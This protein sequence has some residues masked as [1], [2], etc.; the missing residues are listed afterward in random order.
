MKAQMTA[1]QLKNSILQMAV[2]GKLVPQDSKDEPAS[3]LLERIRAEKEQLIKEKKIKKG[4]IFSVIF[5]AADNLPYTFYEKTFDGKVHDI[6]DELPFEIPKSWEWVRLKHIL[7]VKGGKRI[8]KG[9]FLSDI[10]TQNIYIRV[11]DM[12]NN[13]IVSNKLQYISD[14]V[15]KIISKYTIGKDDLYLTIAG[16]IGNVGLVPAMFDEM[17]LTE[18]A[19]KLTNIG[20]DKIFLLY[21]LQSPL[22]QEQFI[23]KTNQVAQPKLAIERILT[24]L[25]PI[26]PLEEQHRILNHLEKLKPYIA[27][28]EFIENK[29]T[30]LNTSF[31]DTLKKSVLQAAVQGKLVKQDPDDESASTLLERIRAEK[32]ELIKNGKIKRNKHESVIIRR[33]NSHYEIIDGVE[34]CIDDEMPFDIPYN[35]EWARL[36]SVVYNHGQI[37][38]Q[39]DFCYIDIGSIDNQQQRINDKDTV[40]SSSKAPS[41]ARKIVKQEDILYSTVRPYL[42]NMCIVNRTFSHIPIASTGFAV[43]ACYKELFNNYLFY[44]LLS[45]DFDH[46]ANDA[47]NAKGVTYPAI[48]DTRLYNALVP[49]PPLLEQQ[50]IVE[51]IEKLLS[52][53]RCIQNI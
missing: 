26:P 23:D 42:H 48:N 27:D 40:I 9:F 5:R 11:T 18:N 21:F 45:P 4:K 25:I 51:K 19:V 28:Y 31:P 14:D 15:Y 7:T 41:R 30:S 10:P 52:L 8:P 13:T 2:Q 37:T 22:V 24:T 49:L 47:K 1:Q 20:I 46:Y 36:D 44:Y 38:P 32:E 34:R 33:D 3:V 16:T 50:C 12:K 6:T 35:W 53:I 43:M 17:N 29:R 39:E